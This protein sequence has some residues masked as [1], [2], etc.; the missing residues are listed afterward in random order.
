MR[1][2]AFVLAA[3]ACVGLKVHSMESHD[4]AYY[5]N[6]LNEK[7]NKD[8]WETKDEK[9]QNL[10]D[11]I[12]ELPLYYN[13]KTKIADWEAAELAV[14]ELTEWKNF[15]KDIKREVI[16]NLHHKLLDRDRVEDIQVQ[17]IASLRCF[18]IDWMRDAMGFF[19][20]EEE[21]VKN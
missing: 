11:K 12:H 19:Q 7:I 4:V 6:F 14:P 5:E 10:C 17:R 3:L 13:W 20:T 16:V 2:F 21:E 9:G 1:C 8:T 15:F 18:F